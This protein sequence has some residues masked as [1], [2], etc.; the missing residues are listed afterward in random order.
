M[1]A[2]STLE[3]FDEVEYFAVSQL[4]VLISVNML[5]VNKLFGKVTFKA[6]NKPAR[7]SEKIG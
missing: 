2:K 1:A 4:F 3:L 6:V 7:T 5:R